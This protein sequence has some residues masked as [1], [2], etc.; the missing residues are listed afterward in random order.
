MFGQSPAILLVTTLIALIYLFIMHRA[1]NRLQMGKIDALFLIGAMFVGGRLP[2]LPLAGNLHANIGGAIIPLG[3]CAYLVWIAESRVEKFRGLVTAL[4][5]AGVIWLIDRTFPLSPGS[6]GYLLDPLYLPAA[7]A[8]GIAYLLGRSRRS[9]FIGGV[10]A[11]LVLDIA[12][13]GENI[14][15]GIHANNPIILGGAGIFDATLVAGVI[16]VMLAEVIG[17]VR[18]RLERGSEEDKG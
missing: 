1:L 10:L 9:A 12:A 2:I 7:V 4:I 3:I 8:G 5:A 14:F 17:E 6:W 18:E 13:W 11:I 16:A 15:R